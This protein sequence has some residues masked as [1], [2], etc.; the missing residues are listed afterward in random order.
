MARIFIDGFETGDTGNWDG[1]GGVGWPSGVRIQPAPA[2]MS[3]TY[4]LQCGPGGQTAYVVKSMTATGTI[5]VSF[6][7][8]VS[9]WAGSS[10]ETRLIYFRNS[11]TT[12]ASIE[13]NPTSH[14]LQVHTGQSVGLLET[15]TYYFSQNSTYHLEVRYVPNDTTGVFQV[16]VND[17]LDIDFTG[18][19]T[20]GAA[21]VD[22]IWIGSILN[23]GSQL[24][25]DDVVIDDDNWIG[26]SRIYPLL[27]TGAGDSTLWTPSA[28]AN[29]ETVDEVP[30][31]DADYVDTDGI[32]NIDLYAASDLP[33]EATI[34]K[35]VQ[36]SSRMYKEVASTPQNAALAVRT[37]GTTYFSPDV[38]VPDTVGINVKNLWEL[39]P[40]TSNPWEIAEVNAL[41]IGYKAQT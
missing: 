23:L 5:I 40:D 14:F 30:P 25:I 37:G 7:V 17:I 24:Y 11:G 20:S 1:V 4:S 13:F 3:G 27:P 12:I 32:G 6:R 26:P 10:Y 16:K 22:N 19:T 39:N 15:G 21:E 29:W 2:G 41:E 38:A 31:S 9:L 28:G 36:V 18:D 8:R 33:L 35:S 34:V